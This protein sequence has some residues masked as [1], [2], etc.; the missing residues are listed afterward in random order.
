M[1]S[2][3][4]VNWGIYL[5]YFIGVSLL[6]FII[7]KSR[8]FEKYVVLLADAAAGQTLNEGPPDL[9]CAFC[10]CEYP[11]QRYV[12]NFYESL[13]Q[14]ECYYGARP[15]WFQKGLNLCFIRLPIS[16]CEDYIFFLL[17]HNTFLSMA[18]T[19]LGS[20]FSRAAK[21]FCF[22]AQSCVTFLLS[23]AFYYTTSNIGHIMIS[24]FLIAPITFLVNRFFYYLMACPC[25]GIISNSG[26][27]M[28]TCGSICGYPFAVIFIIFLLVSST[29]TVRHEDDSSR[30]IADYAWQVHIVAS[31]YD[32][33]LTSLQFIGQ[34]ALLV[35]AGKIEYVING[36]WYTEKLKKE[37][38]PMVDN[39]LFF[40]FF[41]RSRATENTTGKIASLPSYDKVMP[42]NNEEGTIAMR[43]TH[44]P[45][46]SPLPQS[47]NV[48]FWNRS[49][50]KL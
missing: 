38:V 19:V 12:T 33:L 34:K 18:F 4:M 27:Y 30:Y 10:R 16:M 32:L 39:R 6:F 47:I 43:E 37:S 24:V 11:N 29:I 8:I 40:L 25:L 28:R 3:V 42:F 41:I 48:T 46:L 5:G 45:A 23:T 17:N 26:R 21:R 50:Q 13:A 20:K 2:P 14:R 44:S 7:D 31:G 9:K 36:K 1:A 49:P 15:I 35:K 22:F